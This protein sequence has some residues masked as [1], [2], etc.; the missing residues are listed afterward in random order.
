[1]SI[2]A[3]TITLTWDPSAGATGYRLYASVGDS[4][5]AIVTDTASVTASATVSTNLPTRF[6]VTAYNAGGES[7]FGNIYTNQPPPPVGTPVSPS[8]TALSRRRS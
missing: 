6:A 8:T 3:A 2:N 5:L 4:P 7:P 1:M